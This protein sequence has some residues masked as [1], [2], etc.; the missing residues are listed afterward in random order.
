MLRKIRIGVAALMLTGVT[1][2]F[3]DITGAL[4]AWLGWIA[5]LQ[6]FPAVMA[7]NIVVIALLLALTLLFG[8]VY[9]S[10]ICPLG[11]FQDIVSRF[12]KK[13]RF[14]WKPERKWLRYSILV[15]FIAAA[16]FGVQVFVAFLEPYSAYGRM[17]QNLLAPLW[18]WGNNLLAWISARAEQYAFW[19]K[20]VWLRSLPTLI[21]AVVMLVAIVILAVV[22]GRSYCN[23]IC[24]VGT[25][26]GLISRFSMF[27][28]T[29]DT[30][31]CKHCHLCEKKCKGSCI[32]SAEQKIDASRCVACFDCIDNCEFGAIKYRFA[33]KKNGSAKRDPDD[34]GRRSFLA[35]S[36]LFGGSLI[37]NA[38]KKRDGGLAPILPKTKPERTEPITPPGSGSARNFYDKCTACQ[39][40]VAACPNNVLRPS[41]CL[42]R[43]MQ[44]EMSYEKG[45]CRPECTECS[46][47][48]PSGA[49]LPITPEEK[50]SIHFGL[51]VVDRSLC[52]VEKDGVECGNCARHCPVGAIM[53]VSNDKGL[54]IPTVNESRCIG[55]G[56]CENLC[57]ARPLSAITVNGRSTHSI[58]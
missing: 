20:E 19:P 43:L 22:G 6:F 53:M 29:I 7:A 46:K 27:K 42:E 57:P 36:A 1:L 26:L 54:R 23:N 58:D 35:I 10:V 56:A 49:I 50:T 15:L 34:K 30:D 55:C 47:L 4:H 41:S 21:V 31:K 45:Y 12:G 44:P 38:Q 11:I 37:A 40:C 8:R 5:K 16:V 33:W 18:D 25:F 13:K 39:L 48:C 17:V 24:P 51:A 2:L 9:C 28:P 32:N 52:V 14:R 3:L